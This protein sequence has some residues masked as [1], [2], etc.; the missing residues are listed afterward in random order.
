MDHGCL[1]TV[2]HDGAARTSDQSQRGHQ[3]RLGEN[4]DGN[5]LG[6]RERHVGFDMRPEQDA[7]HTVF[8]TQAPHLAEATVHAQRLHA[9]SL[10]SAS[11]ISR[12]APRRNCHQR[13]LA[14]S[15]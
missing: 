8:T 9:D 4:G 13:R 1:P 6:R 14:S 7:H 11:D 2:P 3:S 12:R 10:A 15:T 5:L